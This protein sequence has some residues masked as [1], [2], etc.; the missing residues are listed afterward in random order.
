VRGDHVGANEAAGRPG[1]KRAPWSAT[2]KV[3]DVEENGISLLFF[4]GVPAP[5]WGQ[6]CPRDLWP[7]RRAPSFDGCAVY[8]DPACRPAHLRSSLIAKNSQNS[9]RRL[10]AA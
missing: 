5:V 10:A 7:I 2:P 8:S 9:E 3:A 4:F 6:V 1:P